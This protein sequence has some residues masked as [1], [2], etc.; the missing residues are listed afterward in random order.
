[1]KL[2]ST[3]CA[4]ALLLLLTPFQAARAETFSTCR[5]FINALPAV[6]SQ[7]GTWCLSKD[8]TTRLASGVAI[9]IQ[10]NNVIIDCNDF[11]IGGQAAGTST[12]TVGIR[13]EGWLNT[14]IR[15]CTVRGFHTGIHVGGELSSGHNLRNNRV[16]ASTT[17]G[18]FIAGSGSVARENVV[19]DTFGGAG[20]AVGM[21]VGEGVDLR[22]NLIDSVTPAAADTNAYGIYSYATGGVIRENRIRGVVGTAASYGIYVEGSGRRRIVDNDLFGTGADLS[23]GVFCA[24][25]DSTSLQ[26]NYMGGFKVGYKSCSNDSGNVVR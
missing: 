1:M 24:V 12:Q 10:V 6:I 18:I 15:N 13:N 3:T 23:W 2:A 16:D 25:Q 21:H 5:G 11:K 8:L 7:Q 19:S 9:D 22:E 17:T 20:A 26:S 14:T 4:G